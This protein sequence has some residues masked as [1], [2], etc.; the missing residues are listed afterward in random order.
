MLGWLK[1]LKLLG[2]LGLSVAV[3]RQWSSSPEN[4][5]LDLVLLGLLMLTLFVAAYPHATPESEL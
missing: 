5:L 2:F 1:V 4:K 3:F